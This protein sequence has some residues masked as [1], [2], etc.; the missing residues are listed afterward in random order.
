MRQGIEGLTGIGHV[1]IRVK[2]VERSLDFY[3]GR[4]GFKE[5]LRLER[6][7]RLWLLYLRITDEQYLEIFPDAVGERAPS[8]ETNGLNHVCLTVDSID[9]VVDQL[10]A[11]GI[12]LYR[13]K[14]L[15]ADGNWQAWIEDPDGNRIELME[16]AADGMQAAATARLRQG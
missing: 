5:M 11:A 8:A 2:D 15:A 6:D 13:E 16:M 1:A 9:R 3:I 12:P 4:L 7:G 10:Q 14:K